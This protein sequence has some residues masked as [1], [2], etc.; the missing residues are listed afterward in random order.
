MVDIWFGRLG[1]ARVIITCEHHNGDGSK[2]IVLSQKRQHI[3]ATHIGH[4]HI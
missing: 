4:I 2:P 3:Q 1:N